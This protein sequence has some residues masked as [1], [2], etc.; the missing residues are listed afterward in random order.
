MAAK[1]PLASTPGFDAMA[2]KGMT[3]GDVLDWLDT[4]ESQ[5]YGEYLARGR[6]EFTAKYPEPLDIF[7]PPSAPVI[8]SS[9]PP[10][11]FSQV[12]EASAAG[13]LAT[14]KSILDNWERN[15]H[16]FSTALVPALE[17]GH[18]N[19][20]CCLLEHGASVEGVHFKCAMEHRLYPFLELCLRHGF[21][22]ND[23]G[24]PFRPTPLAEYLGDEGMTR[25]LLDHGADP[26]AESVIN[27]AKMGETPLSISMLYTPFS[28]VKL[29]LERG[30][31]ESI[32][33]GHLLWYAVE[34][35]LPDRFEVLEYL[36]TNGA[37]G[38]LKRLQYH[39][40]PE[41]AMQADWF[42][43][44]QTPLHGAARNGDLDVV[45]LFVAW[46]ADPTMPDSKGRLAIDE[47]RKQ[48]RMKESGIIGTTGDHE[49]LIE[50]LASLSRQAGASIIAS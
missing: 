7:L 28:T 43:G 2:S 32:K 16:S 10:V 44:R 24:F 37:A 20:A 9:P 42:L 12:Q 41:A 34:R 25:W 17:N 49:G 21:D 13:D 50:Y 29:L 11:E 14:V 8:S 18:V 30:G 23:N 6:E 36:L 35:K 27:G 1:D 26:N 48:M 45:K 46:G 4:E 33:Y 3:S 47:A 22:I 31:P 40:R 19:V 15:M 39:D 5:R 38:D